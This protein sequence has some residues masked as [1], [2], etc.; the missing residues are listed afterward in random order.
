MKK[1][2]DKKLIMYVAIALLVG[3]A[4]GIGS[5][6]LGGVFQGNLVSTTTGSQSFN[7]VTC[8]DVA[9]AMAAGTY[10]STYSKQMKVRGF[11]AFV[12]KCMDAKVTECFKM[13]DYYCTNGAGAFSNW[14]KT[15]PRTTSTAHNSCMAIWGAGKGG[16]YTNCNSRR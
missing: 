11:S 15:Q 13:N 5:S 7:G 16:F 6:S 1:Q 9:N 14:L 12:Q 3:F 4:A 8:N 2:L 10:S